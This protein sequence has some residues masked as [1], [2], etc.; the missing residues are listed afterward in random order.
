[1]I[2]T[3]TTSDADLVA[4]TLAGDRA[5]FGRIVE[6]YQRLLCSL[7][8]SAVGSLSES[9]DIAQEAFVEAWQQLRGLR[10]P[11]K[12]RSWLC[13]ILRHK[14]G[15]SRRRAHQ[16]PVNHAVDPELAD[17]I[18]SAETSAPDHTIHAEEQ[19]ILWHALERVPARYREPLVLY[20][21]EHRSIE[22]V[23][24][25]L[26]LSEDNVKQRLSRGRK[27]LKDQALAFVEGAL[28]RSTPGKVFTIGVLASLPVL[29]PPAKAAGIGAAAA[30]ATKGV[31][32]VAKTTLLAAVLASVSGF[33][34]SV[35]TLRMNLDQ[36]RTP[37]ERRTV[38]RMTV[39]LLGSAVTFMLLVLGGAMGMRAYPQHVGWAVPLHHAGVVSFAVVWT[40]LIGRMLRQQR[41]LRSAERV[42]D[43]EAF[44]DP[45]DQ[46][47]SAASEYRSKRKFLGVPLVHIRFGA[48]DVGQPPVFGWVAGGDRAIGLLFAWGGW[49]VGCFSGGAVSFGLVSFGAVSFGVIGLGAVAFGGI[50]LGAVSVGYHAVASISATAWLSAQSAILAISRFIAVGKVAIAPHANDESAL[51]M[52]ANPHAERDGLIFC[53][54]MVTL[55]LVPTA[56]YARAVR[57]R[58]K[59]TRPR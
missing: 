32:S 6:R 13:G 40:V 55:A 58:M 11:E 49:A 2:L 59:L 4:A 17:Q 20:Y 3:E 37:A 33:I 57:R 24:V 42:R 53:I 8:Y 10:D 35:M 12:L 31:G 44:A 23:A 56:I 14:V 5:A 45:R 15:R 48:A 29:A 52:L 41:E 18:P 19:A 26:D 22:H 47:G 28:S 46:V 30:A 50:A 16:E 21:R 39:V 1:M 43:R 34:A 38:V 25:E 27:M 51:A 36:A 7:A 54:V 9:E